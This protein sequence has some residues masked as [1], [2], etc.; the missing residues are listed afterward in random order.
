MTINL[1]HTYDDNHT[2]DR[3]FDILRHVAIDTG[4]LSIGIRFGTGTVTWPGGSV[5]SDVVTI[6]HGLATTPRSIQFTPIATATPA[7]IFVSAGSVTSTTFGARG[8]T[9]DGS[10]PAAA[11]TQTFYWLVIG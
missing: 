1:E 11:S 4:G 8:R 6:D 9:T 7:D 5:N 2:I 10:S 3:N